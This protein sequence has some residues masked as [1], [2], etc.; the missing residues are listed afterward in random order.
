MCVITVTLRRRLHF[1][2]LTSWEAQDNTRTLA[3]LRFEGLEAETQVRGGCIL[4]RPGPV[5]RAV[6]LLSISTR[7][8]GSGTLPS[9]SLGLEVSTAQD[10]G[11]SCKQGEK[12]PPEPPTPR[13]PGPV[14][15]GPCQSSG[16]SRGDIS[17]RAPPPLG[18]VRARPA[19]LPPG[20]QERRLL[21][22]T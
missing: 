6:H 3:R 17:L 16:P 8:L 12:A 4:G 2:F 22:G 18:Q 1:T 10:P 13:V 21:G 7:P 20:G 5:A 11:A 15:R 19:S 14:A 9:P